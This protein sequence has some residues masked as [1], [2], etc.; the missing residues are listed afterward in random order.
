[1]AVMA[2]DPSLVDWCAYD[3]MNLELGSLGKDFE[4]ETFMDSRYKGV[5]VA[6]PRLVTEITDN[7][8]RGLDNPKYATPEMGK[9]RLKT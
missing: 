8:W 7:G 5:R 6:V 1:M 2:I 3:G 9:E 4:I